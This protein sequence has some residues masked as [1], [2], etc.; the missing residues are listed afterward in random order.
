MSFRRLATTAAFVATGLMSATTAS[1]VTTWNF[2]YSAPGLTAAGSFTTA[3]NAL[4]PEDILSIS[5]VRNGIAI[6]GLVPL[7]TDPDFSYDNQFTATAPNFTSDGMVYGLSNGQHINVYFFE[8][9]YADL[10][11]LGGATPVE[12]PINWS[13]VR[14]PVP[15]PATVLSMLAGLGLLGAFMR[16]ARSQG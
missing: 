11:V 7:G 3:G 13:V 1:A 4:V 9:A 14:A 6:T 5:G 10:Y 12:T 8:G 16:R 15:E 2:N